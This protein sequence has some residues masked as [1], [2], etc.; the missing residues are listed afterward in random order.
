MTKKGGRPR[1]VN[2]R[3]AQRM[4]EAGVPLEDILDSQDVPQTARSNHALMARVE[5]VVRVGNA[6]HRVSVARRLEREGVR[7]GKA[8]S[9]LSL[10]RNRLK[11]DASGPPPGPPHLERIANATGSLMAIM[12]K[13]ERAASGPNPPAW[14]VV[15]I[16]CGGEK[17]SD[18]EPQG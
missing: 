17:G 5:H 10:A 18:G 14:A 13:L 1:T 3:E 9:L 8:H 16:R 6:K 12:E 4:A 2:M 15:C 7:R 11:F